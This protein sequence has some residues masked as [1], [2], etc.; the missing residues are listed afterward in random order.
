MKRRV[1]AVTSSR[2]D[3]GLLRHTLRA[4]Q[5]H[6]QLELQLLVTGSHLSERFGLTVREIEADGAIVDFTVDLELDQRGDSS[7]DIARIFASA[8]VGVAEVIQKSRP[9]ILLV[10]GDRYEIL[11]ACT[12]ALLASTPV[13]HIHGG[14]LT[15][16]AFDDSIRHAITKIASLHFPVHPAYAARI[17]QLGEHPNSVI[18]IDPPVTEVLMQLA[19]K[20]RS[21]LERRLGIRLTDP[22]VVVS[23]HP[24]T[25]A[26]DV[27]IL[28]LEAT[29][30]ALESL[31]N[32][33]YVV[34]GTNAD[35]M[36]QLHD[37]LLRD[38]VARS[39]E[40]RAFAKSLGHDTYLSLLKIAAM[41]VGNSSSGVIEAPLIGTPSLNIGMRQLG[42]VH[43]TTVTS[44]VGD[45]REIS[46]AIKMIL[47]NPSKREPAIGK[48]PTSQLISQTLATCELGRPKVFNDV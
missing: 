36:N 47:D 38:F 46:R 13:A 32:V 23:Y 11:A 15:V 48:Q 18:L 10:L 24:V 35:P 12:A 33:T 7:L 21:E 34:T 42:R 14:E 2:S 39:P 41:V 5:I 44:V 17:R 22:I 25:Q 27:S 20:S 26:Q 45:E 19:P 40:S 30:R 3:Y 16:G 37:K 29:L 31:S 8:T 6:N 28:D 4:I 43:P 9:D 1:L